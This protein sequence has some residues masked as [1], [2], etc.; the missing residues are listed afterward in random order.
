MSPFWLFVIVF[1]NAWALGLYLLPRLGRQSNAIVNLFVGAAFGAANFAVGGAVHAKTMTAQPAMSMAVV[2]GIRFLLHTFL[3]LGFYRRPTGR[4]AKVDPWKKWSAA[5]LG[6]VYFAAV[7]LIFE[8][9]V[10]AQPGWANEEL[11]FNVQS[12]L[13]VFL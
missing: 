8:I 2:F 3:L 9:Y 5:A 7:G 13:D 4:G 10:R 12:V 1:A 11:Y 6:G